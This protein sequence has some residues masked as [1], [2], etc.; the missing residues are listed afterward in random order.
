MKKFKELQKSEFL[1]WGVS[2]PVQCILII[3]VIQTNDSYQNQFQ[4][5]KVI[6]KTS[7]SY[8]VHVFLVWHACKHYL[9]DYEQ[10]LFKILIMIILFDLS[11]IAFTENFK[12]LSTRSLYEN[13]VFN[14]FPFRIPTRNWLKLCRWSLHD[15]INIML[16]PLVVIR[17]VYAIYHCVGEM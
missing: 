9:S 3:I 1:N 11:C 8:H 16:A 10:K 12:I 13:V 17:F 4:I 7:L 6:L 14:H 5:F 2:F 15:L